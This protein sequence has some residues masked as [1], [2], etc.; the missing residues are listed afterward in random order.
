MAKTEIEVTI[1][2]ATG[3]ITFEAHGVKGK[4]CL[5]KLKEFV[6]ALGEQKGSATPTREMHEVATIQAGGKR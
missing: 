5:S 4:G 1:D 2:E 6:D 3:E